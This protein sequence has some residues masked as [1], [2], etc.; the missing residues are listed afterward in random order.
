MWNARTLEGPF[1]LIAIGVVL[2]L[3]NFGVIPINWEQWWP[4]L[5]IVLGAL[6]I[7][8]RSQRPGPAAVPGS[9]SPE[10]GHPRRHFGG[11]VFL[12]G[13]GVA[14][15]VSNTIGRGSFPALVL[16]AIGLASLVNR[17]G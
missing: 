2:L 10:P 7:V 8:V 5:L 3:W 9:V 17:Y 15:L 11:G 6:A 14:F 12:I 4:V 16:I 1:V 13:I